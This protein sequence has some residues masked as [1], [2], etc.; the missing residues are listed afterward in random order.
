MS[1]RASQLAAYSFE[2]P[3][4]NYAFFAS[5]LRWLMLA[6]VVGAVLWGMVQIYDRFLRGAR[7]QELSQ[8]ADSG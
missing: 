8:S 5:L 2:W 1:D 4:L 7:G 6:V 3:V